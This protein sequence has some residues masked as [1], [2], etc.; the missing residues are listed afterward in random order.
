MTRM[1]TAIL[2]YIDKLFD[3]LL[4]VDAVKSVCNDYRIGGS[5]TSGADFRDD[6][7]Y[8]KTFID[9]CGSRKLPDGQKEKIHI[10]T[11]LAVG[12]TAKGVF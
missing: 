12:C 11:P 8:L 3:F 4:S 7:G 2:G 9:F 10:I 1:K 6:L 5:S